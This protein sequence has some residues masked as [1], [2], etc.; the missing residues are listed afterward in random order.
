VHNTPKIIDQKDTSSQA[1]ERIH[2]SCGRA[3]I[4]MHS[5]TRRSI[6]SIGST[7][8][9]SCLRRLDSRRYKTLQA[10][11]CHQC[12]CVRILWQYDGDVGTLAITP[13]IGAGFSA[14]AARQPA[15]PRATETFCRS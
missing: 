12:N 3:S 10:G 13:S 5:L 9:R 14:L 11:D 1:V 6:A 8:E 4:H 2:N 15:A 7:H